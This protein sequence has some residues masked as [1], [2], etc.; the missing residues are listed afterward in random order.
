LAKIINDATLL[1]RIYDGM[2]PIAYAMAQKTPSP[3]KRHTIPQAPRQA[4]YSHTKT[5]AGYR[6]IPASRSRRSVSTCQVNLFPR[7][8]K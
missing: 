6:G 5:N 3:E 4:P 1:W 2:E 7:V 8:P